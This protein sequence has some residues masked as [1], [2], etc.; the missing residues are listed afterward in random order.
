MDLVSVVNGKTGLFG[1][2]GD[3]VEHTKSP[4]IY[5][6]LFNQYNINAIYVP[7]HVNKGCL[8][9]VVKGLRAQN[10]IGFNVTVPF[11][12]DI[13][14]YLDDIS[15]DAL[16]MGAVN[17]VKNIN[18]KLKGYNTDAEGFSR[19]FKDGFNT[20][21][22]G[23]RVLL[24]GAGGTTRALTIKLAA[25]GIQHLAIAN[26]TELHAQNIVDLVK[27]NYGSIVSY[28]DPKASQ[29][30]DEMKSFQ[31]IIN[32]TPAGMS[33]YLDSTPFDFEYVFDKDQLV[34]DV[35]YSPKKTK[36]LLQAE[37]YGCKTRN[38]FGMLIN[39]GV[40]AFE[41]WTGKTVAR[42]QAIELLNLID[43]LEDLHK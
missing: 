10:F 11:K 27:N 15:N 17:T 40:S 2:L 39:Q 18:G 19:D 12:K 4:F 35:I 9:N 8:E 43:K 13:I 26:R 36:F 25:E 30:L 1:L 20:N 5:N 38:G 37:S 42:Q 24:L 3:P 14:K 22:K 16:L 21:F 23:K 29:F 33:T 28:L 41:I 6:T 31:I 32:T 34:Y 7:I